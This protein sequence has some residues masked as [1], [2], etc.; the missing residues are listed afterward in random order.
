M[1]TRKYR[2]HF[3]ILKSTIFSWAQVPDKLALRKHR[4]F[5]RRR[6]LPL[7]TLLWSILLR[8]SAPICQTLKRLFPKITERPSEA[9]FYKRRLELDPFGLRDMIIDYS[10]RLNGHIP[11]VKQLYRGKY[12]ILAVDGTDIP[13]KTNKYEDE[14]Q[15]NNGAGRSSYSLHHLTVV[16]NTNSH[17]FEDL[18]LSPG[19]K[20][21]EK[22]ALA[23]M[24]DHFKKNANL[25]FV[26][27]RA[28]DCAVLPIVINSMGNFFL[29]RAK[30]PDSN[31]ILH[32]MDLPED[33]TYDVVIPVPFKEKNASTGLRTKDNKR[34]QV[35]DKAEADIVMNIRIVKFC[36]PN[37]SIDYFMT[38]LPHELTKR[39]IINLYHKRWEVE[40]AFR[41]FKYPA[42]ALYLHSRNPQIIMQEVLMSILLCN[43][44]A[45]IECETRVPRAGRKYR[46][47]LSFTALIT[48]CREFIFRK[49]N[50]P[51]FE[52]RIK[53]Q[54][55][56]IRT[57]RSSERKQWK[58]GIVS[59][60]YRGL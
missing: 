50:V 3:N 20:G 14:S 42:G 29:F 25:V 24:L 9:A 59:F 35:C 4:G 49:G 19:R 48:E 55:V 10:Q 44:C 33:N 17:I 16:Y 6:L 31:G 39:M 5:T 23:C 11:M 1:A 57:S 15:F 38:N 47:K 30:D 32:N 13:S 53:D 7:P 60:T 18:Q 34:Y 40:T 56:P 54:Q 21:G 37:G 8:L 52:E 27:D 43:F 28:F 12:R 58:K 45:A 26:A 46:Y 2:Q 22:Q 41:N 51:D 36:F